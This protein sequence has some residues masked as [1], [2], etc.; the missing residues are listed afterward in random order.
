MP[1][2]ASDDSADHRRPPI[3]FGVGYQHV[4]HRKSKAQQYDG[5][6]L[7]KQIPKKRHG[8]QE[9]FSPFQVWPAGQAHSHHQQKRHQTDDTPIENHARKPASS[10]R[11]TPDIV[12][13]ILDPAQHRNSHKNERNTA[14]HSQGT[15]LRFLNPTFAAIR[16][17]LSSFF[18]SLLTLKDTPYRSVRS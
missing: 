13:R 15:A 9:P 18:H 1:Q 11:D 3:H 7:E 12:E 5:Q 2:H 17:F 8:L 4:E 6:E 16:T 10:A 14:G